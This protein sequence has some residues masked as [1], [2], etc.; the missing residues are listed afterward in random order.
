MYDG[1]YSLPLAS[2][3]HF[4]TNSINLGKNPY[5]LLEPPPPLLQCTYDTMF[6]QNI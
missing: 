2:F 4:R 3:D 5:Q 1:R 6:T